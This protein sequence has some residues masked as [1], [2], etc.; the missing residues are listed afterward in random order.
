M[1]NVGECFLYRTDPVSSLEGNLQDRQ[2]ERAD[3]RLITNVVA[4]D[5]RLKRRQQFVEGSFVKAL[6]VSRI[7]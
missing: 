3:P 1:N 5:L 7:R 4:F 2:S 6:I